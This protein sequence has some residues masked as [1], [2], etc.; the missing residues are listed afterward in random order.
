MLA[1]L[2]YAVGCFPRAFETAASFAQQSTRV[3]NRLGGGASSKLVWGLSMMQAAH[4][5]LAGEGA[6]EIVMKTT[7]AKQVMP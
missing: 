7:I 6:L 2:V 3:T 1:W 5:K 4:P